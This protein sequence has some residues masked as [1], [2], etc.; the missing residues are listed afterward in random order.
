MIL[1]ILA[2]PHAG[3]QTAKEKI[4]FIKKHYPTL[5]HKVYET[6]GP[7]DEYQQVSAILSQ[8]DKT[9]DRLLI[10]GGDGTLS[11][12]L[13][14]LPREIPFAYFP[15]GSGNDFARA[16]Q[17]TNL[18]QVIAGLLR[19]EARPIFVLETELGPVVNSLDMGYAAQV[20]AYT[21]HSRLK[22]WLNALKCGKLTYL[23]FGI[24]SLFHP[25]R[26]TIQLEIDGRKERLH[27]VFFLSL[28]NSA[29]FGGGIMIWP[30]AS[31]EE[32]QID[33]V[34]F[35]YGSIWQRVAA[36]L[37][38][39]CRSHRTS[40]Y[41]H[42]QRAKR[43]FLSSHHPLSVQVD[44]ELKEMKNLTLYCQQRWIYL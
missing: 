38:L 3:S 12:V 8:Y 11:K 18:S 40:P 10:L 42:H 30:D 19:G 32:E 22:A 5:S 27:D 34:Y 20:I 1:H 39:L 14:V 15:T 4:A 25:I 37:S 26:L 9:K 2:N 24:R 35:Q 17:L 6:N 28:A 41:L 43:V 21:E 33:L 16:M 23:L 29:Y 13:S 36:L 7:D 44:G 31:V